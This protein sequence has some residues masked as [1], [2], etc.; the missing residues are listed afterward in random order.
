MELPL[1]SKVLHVIHYSV[2]TCYDGL[3]TVRVL[4]GVRDLF[5]YP[6]KP[7]LGPTQPPLHW[8]TKALSRL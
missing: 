6:S 7:A 8:G 5:S 1:C 2:A 4:L 3:S